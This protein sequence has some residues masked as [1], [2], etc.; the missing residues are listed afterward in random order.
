MV[1]FRLEFHL[2][3]GHSDP[4]WLP[5][6]SGWRLHCSNFFFSAKQAGRLVSLP[7]AGRVITFMSHHHRDEEDFDKSFPTY[8]IVDN[9][10]GGVDAKRVDKLRTAIG[11][12]FKK[13]ANIV[14]KD[15][16]LPLNAE[17]KTLGYDQGSN[18]RNNE[19]PKNVSNAF[20]HL[21]E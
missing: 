21:H 1:K 5:A 9:I 8:V 11:K 17:G 15:I 2:D 19:K 3:S 18:R 4:G 20:V 13:E 16:E 7:W 14:V 10:P 6:K 12:A